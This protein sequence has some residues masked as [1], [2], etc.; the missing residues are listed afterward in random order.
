MAFKAESVYTAGATGRRIGMAGEEAVEAASEAAAGDEREILVP[1]GERGQRLDR[2]LAAAVSGDAGLSRTRLKALVES[3]AVSIDGRV[4]AD[5]NHTLRGGMRISLR[6]PAPVAAEPQGEDIAL[7][8]V[9]EDDDLIVIDKPAGLVV[10]PA[11]GNKAGTLV[12]ALIAHCGTSLSG[13]GGV[14]R[15]GIVHR[16][17]KDTSG[18]M[19]VAKT[20]LAHR[21]LAAQ[22]ADHGRSGPLERAYLAFVW[23]T[24]KARGTVETGIARST[25]TR[26]KMAVVAPERGRIAITHFSLRRAFGDP[27]APLA[28]L[29][30]CRL[31]TGRTHQIRVH[32]AHLG[33]PLLGDPL[34]GPGFRTKA[35]LLPE[36]AR[37]ALTALGRQALH[38]ALLGFEHPRTKQHLRFESAL[39]DDLL[40]LEKTLTRV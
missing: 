30:E 28:S 35:S 12:N 10:H 18:L 7:R 5:A 3:G 24:P 16:L 9:Y 11:A 31:E 13:I 15:P 32:M 29:V 38:A 39:P 20:D 40:R 37:A 25:R 27:G 2:F 21:G 14:L 23:G 4:V 17:D 8:V 6:V 33:H 26:E 1:D 34:Y 22:F 19:V 36:E